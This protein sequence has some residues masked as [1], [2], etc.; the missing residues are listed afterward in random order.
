[1][2][3]NPITIL[4]MVDNGSDSD[5]QSETKLK[6]NSKPSGSKTAFV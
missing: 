6:E 2:K 1:M 5:S 3:K 4:K